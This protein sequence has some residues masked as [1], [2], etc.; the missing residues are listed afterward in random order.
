MFN[1]RNPGSLGLR[2]FVLLLTLM[3]AID[4]QAQ[5]VDL[6]WVD[7]SEHRMELR[8]GDQVVR[9]YQ[10]ALG[11]GG[12]EPKRQEGDKLVP[13][14]AY[15]IEGRNPNSA[16]YLSLKI[17][18][19]NE[20]DKK[21]AAKEGV[22]PGFD[23]MIHGLPNKTGWLG[24]LHRRVDWTL[25]CIAVTNEEMDEIWALVKDGTKVQIQQ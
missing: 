8:S 2:G 24:A 1:W 11:R 15:V 21:R 12:L 17:S 10:V 22:P 20:E 23:I 19:P 25:G 3:F 14:G 13:E 6:I 4:A 7:K 18:Y 16:Y 5:E 9:S